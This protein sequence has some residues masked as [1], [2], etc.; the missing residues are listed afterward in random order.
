M[1]AAEEI[2]NSGRR[3]SKEE[4]L[5]SMKTLQLHSDQKRKSTKRKKGWKSA[6][7]SA[8]P[9]DNMMIFGMDIDKLKQGEVSSDDG[10]GSDSDASDVQPKKKEKEDSKSGGKK[11][12]VDLRAKVADAALKKKIGKCF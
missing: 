4:V 1:S 12:V 10:S 7:K 2:E 6:K 11:P 5:E 3:M 9:E 8:L